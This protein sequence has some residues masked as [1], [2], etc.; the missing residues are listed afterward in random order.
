[1]SLYANLS[2]FTLIETLIVVLILSV[3]VLVAQP[4]LNSS[5]DHAKL[6]AAADEPLL[7]EAGFQS[8]DQTLTWI[9]ARSRRFGFVIDEF[10]YLVEAN[11]ALPSLLQRAWDQ[12]LSG[13]KAFLVLCGSSVAMMEREVLSER[14]PLYGRRTGHT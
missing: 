14:A 2:G 7:A 3:A 4:A 5:V 13:T 12:E 8:W 11:P 1:M 10:P 9:A 6:S